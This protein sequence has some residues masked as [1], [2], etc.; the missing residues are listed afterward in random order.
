MAQIFGGGELNVHTLR[1][2]HDSDFPSQTVRIPG[3]IAAHNDGAAFRR[4]HQC[5][6]YAK[7][8]GL[9]AAVGTKKAKQLGALHLEG[10]AVERNSFI[11]AMPDVID[12]YGGRGCWTG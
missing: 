2:K 10:N 8:R 3:S 7:E 5:G 6:K 4:Q 12:D 11:V 9:A 1:L